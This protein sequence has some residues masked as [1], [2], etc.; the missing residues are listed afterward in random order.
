MNR[1]SAVELLINLEAN[2]IVT[3]K[4]G[5][6]K[7]TLLHDA[8]IP[9]SRYFDFAEL[10]GEDTWPDPCVLVEE[11]C[12]H[13]EPVFF[14]TPEKNLILDAVEFPGNIDN[15]KIIHL[16]KTA[17]KMGKRLII[18]SYPDSTEMVLRHCHNLFG[19]VIYLDMEP[20]KKFISYNARTF[21]PA[22]SLPPVIKDKSLFSVPADSR[23][24]DNSCCAPFLEDLYSAIHEP[25]RLTFTCYRAG[26]AVAELGFWRAGSVTFVL[27][28][29]EGRLCIPPISDDDKR[30]AHKEIELPDIT[31]I[32]LLVTRLAIRA[33]LQPSL[34]SDAGSASVFD[35]TACPR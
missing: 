13:F 12:A 9:D 25:D 27:T 28:V 8:N 21:P 7:S 15:S 24:F 34:S 22:P 6:G 17:K 1:Q 23:V 32:M 30:V 4:T 10:A 11:S 2:I 33:G 29:W 16:I 14:N 20:E 26:S 5:A 31:D 35:F 18:A 3:G 19:A